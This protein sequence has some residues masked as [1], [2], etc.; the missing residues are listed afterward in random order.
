M[1]DDLS[2]P[3]K[4]YEKPKV[5]GMEMIDTLL[6][7]IKPKQLQNNTKQNVETVDLESSI[8]EIK[9]NNKTPEIY[10]ISDQAPPFFFK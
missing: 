7:H 8:S 10:E 1:D 4:V 2:S 3:T 6:E 5:S 9:K